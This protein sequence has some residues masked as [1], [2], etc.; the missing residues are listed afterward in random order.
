MKENADASSQ[1]A[2]ASSKRLQQDCAHESAHT[3][4]RSKD[5]TKT[6]QKLPDQLLR[7]HTISSK[8]VRNSAQGKTET[9]LQTYYLLYVGV[10]LSSINSGASKLAPMR[11]SPCIF[12]AQWKWFP[13]WLDT[14]KKFF[15]LPPD[16]HCL[17][18]SRMSLIRTLPRDLMFCYC[19]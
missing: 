8:T 15:R 13:D 3:S 12:V 17:E 7:P 5:S 18:R 16:S 14:S 1:K 11:G 4:P 19:G 2:V 10:S 6:Q 9:V